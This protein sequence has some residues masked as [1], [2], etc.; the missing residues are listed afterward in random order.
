LED[1]I[2]RD[3][4]QYRQE[5]KQTAELGVERAR[6]QV[7]LPDIGDIGRGRPRA[8]WTFVIGPAW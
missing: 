6:A 8:W 3:R 7:E 5:K 2:Q 1:A 4:G